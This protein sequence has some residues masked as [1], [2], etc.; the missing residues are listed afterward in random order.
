M[1][2]PAGPPDFARVSLDALD[3][4]ELCSPHPVSTSV[5]QTAAGTTMPHRAVLRDLDWTDP[6]IPNDL[7]SRERW[8]VRRRWAFIPLIVSQP[9]S[10]TSCLVVCFSHGSGTPAS[11]AKRERDR[12]GPAFVGGGASPR[13]SGPVPSTEPRTPAR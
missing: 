2:L 8:K 1:A 4:P 6:L 13:P 11:R 9:R 10:L 5:P 12:R 3:A 7:T